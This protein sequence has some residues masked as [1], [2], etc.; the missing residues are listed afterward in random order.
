MKC[1]GILEALR[2]IEMAKS[3]GMKTMLGCMIESSIGVTAA[4]HLSPL[5]DYADLDGNLLIAN[6]PYTGVKVDQGKLV[7][8][9]RPGLGLLPVAE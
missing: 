6:D 7:L 4:A 3:L 1:G 5:V 2:M 8:P 9:D